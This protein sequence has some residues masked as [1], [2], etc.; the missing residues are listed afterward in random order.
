MLVV[1]RF[2]ILA[3]YQIRRIFKTHC[4]STKVL[5]RLTSENDY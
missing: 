2:H 3:L 1:F 5:K 4:T